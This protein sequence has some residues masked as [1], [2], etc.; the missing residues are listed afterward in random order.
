MT[1]VAAASVVLFAGDLEATFA[2]GLGLVGTSLLHRG[3]ELLDRQGGLAAYARTGAV[4]GIPLLHPWANRLSGHGYRVGGQEVRLPAGPPLVH[5]EEH[6]LPIHGLLAAS[7]HWQVEDV[8][9]RHLRA[10]LDF[11]AHADLLAAF[12]FPHELAVDLLLQPGALTVTTTVRA[13]G[14]VS[15]PISFGFHPYLRLPGVARDA[16]EVSLPA[17][18]HLLSDERGI[19]TGD[20]EMEAA[21]RF[22]LGMRSFDDGYDGLPDGAEFSV[23][24]GGR[25]IAVRF[26]RGYPV[27]QVFAP[28]GRP[29][30][31]FEPMTAPTDALSTGTGL[32]WAAPGS[33]FTAAYSI[34]V[35]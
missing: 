19:P 15:V 2:P 29:F 6:G 9:A 14:R 28:A 16:W 10:T 12:P 26:G 33:V 17:R 8:D 22:R 11:A 34:L 18:R 20:V 27:G 23:S 1:A 4:M 24:G 32:R 21:E 25:T 30:I 5:C 31:C 35:S 7:P 13:T 3:E